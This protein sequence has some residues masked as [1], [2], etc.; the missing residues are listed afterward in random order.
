MLRRIPAG[1][2]EIE[3]A[4]ERD[5]IVDDDDL[6]VVRRADRM[7]AV[8][9]ELEPAVRLPV[10]LEHGQPLALER[11]H[12][13]EI[14]RQRVRAQT[15]A[16]CRHCVQEVAERL[17]KAVVRAFGDEPQPAVD[18]PADDEDRMARGGDR[19][20][21]RAEIRIGVDQ[22]G[23]PMRTLDAPAVAPG[24][25][26]RCEARIVALRL[27][28]RGCVDNGRWVAHGHSVW[29]PERN[30]VCSPRAHKR[31]RLRPTRRARHDGGGWRAIS[32]CFCSR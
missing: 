8:E 5:G 7:L 14:P 24:D 12:H 19:P 1:M 17:R 29:P 16:R 20:A 6:L 21:H 18:V 3:A 22:H 27:R 25:E 30:A 10:E 4:D 2:R 15:A 11:I 23:Q 13:R 28:T 31:L 32:A 9:P 26:Q